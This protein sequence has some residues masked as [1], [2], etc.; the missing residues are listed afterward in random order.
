MSELANVLIVD[1]DADIRK[2]LQILLKNK[3]FV[4]EACDGASAVEYVSAHPETDL[5][6]LDVMMPGL[7][8]FETCDK[9]RAVTNAPILFLTAK[10]AQQDRLS[11]YDMGG[12][13]FLSKP[14]SHEELLAKVRS[15]LRRYREY[16]GKDYDSSL[17]IGDMDV[18]FATRTVRC[19]GATVALTDT[20]YAI[21]DYMLRHRGKVVTAAELYEAVWGEKFLSTSGNTVMV[22]VL[23]MRRK[24][25]SDP[26]SPKIIRTV[27][28]KGY[29]ID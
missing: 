20:E 10:S 11:A 19:M 14:F 5:I 12:D 21:L 17:T 28:G 16:R 27:W 29:Q 13:D 23:N 8:G 3:Y 22:H 24:L 9:L 15:L 4:A 25:E 26:S 1:D 2:V 18:D 6:I 7:N